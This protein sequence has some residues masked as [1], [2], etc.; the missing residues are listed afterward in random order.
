M[1]YGFSKSVEIPFEQA[2]E[3]V[4]DELK[5]EG[6]GILTTID[7]KETLKNKINVDVEK[8]TILG[9][10]NPP[11]AHRSIQAEQEIGLFLPCN[12][13]VYEKAGKTNVSF[14]NTEIMSQLIENEEVEKVAKEVKV[15][16]QK[17]YEAI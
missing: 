15:K 7:V 13:L 4:T 17:V 6:F 3:R 2:I 10:C 16:L 14:F 11:L 5:K 1:N 12:V 9:A 8:Y